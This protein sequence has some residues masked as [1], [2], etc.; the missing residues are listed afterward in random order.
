MR[1]DRYLTIAYVAAR[2]KRSKIQSKISHDLP[3]HGWVSSSILPMRIIPTM[4][5]SIVCVRLTSLT[6][7]RNRKLIIP[8]A[9]KCSTL[10]K[11]PPSKHLGSIPGGK[12][13]KKHHRSK[14]NR[15]KEPPKFY[16]YFVWSSKGTHHY[17]LE[18]SLVACEMCSHL[19]PLNAERLQAN[20]SGLYAYAT[21][22]YLHETETKCG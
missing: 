20:D 14:S 5:R 15:R 22:I 13:G 17:Q 10:S 9:A 11:P 12:W 8:Y 7:I 19:R 2:P 1:I 4:T 3:A 18:Q 21:H 16:K 6:A